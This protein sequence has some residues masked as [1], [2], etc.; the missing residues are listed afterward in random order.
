MNPLLQGSSPISPGRTTLRPINDGK[1]RNTRRLN[2]S[3]SRYQSVATPAFMTCIMASPQSTST[4]KSSV[5][6]ER[7]RCASVLCSVH[8]DSEAIGL[9]YACHGEHVI[10]MSPTRTPKKHHSIT[11]TPR[12]ASPS[13]LSAWFLYVPSWCIRTP[14][15]IWSLHPIFLLS[16]PFFQA[17]SFH[18]I[19]QTTTLC[20]RPR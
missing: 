17:S 18:L 19:L 5:R 10:T 3:L 11:D 9:E 4:S 12:T 6:L 8:L 16:L 20:G 14:Y 15:R 13:F 1:R 2:L 7:E